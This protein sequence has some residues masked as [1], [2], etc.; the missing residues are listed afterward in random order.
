VSVTESSAVQADLDVRLRAELGMPFLPTVFTLLA[1]HPTYLRLATESFLAQLPDALDEHA[2]A[3]RAVGASA[4]PALALSAWEVGPAAPSIAA[5]IDSYNQVNPPSL[6]FTLSLS[7]APTIG[8]GVMEPPLPEPP[9]A[10]DSEALLADID[11]CHG[12]FKVPGFWREL[13]ARWPRQA[14]FAWKLVRR[15]P[16]NEGFARAR[17]AVRLL[18]LD[19][20]PR[21]AVPAP[22]DMGCSRMEGEHIAR[23]LSFYAVVIPTMLVEIECL[24]HA[25]ALAV[26]TAGHAPGAR[27]R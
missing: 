4:A 10:A 20:T 22:S 3:V 17:E 26:P 24:R 2:R 23:I 8:S 16:E 11:V 25:L 1:D 14:A 9:P 21:G 15:L 13:V 27:G 6:L 5:L 12:G 7:R 18:A 19:K